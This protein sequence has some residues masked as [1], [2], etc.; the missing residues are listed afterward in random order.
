VAEGTL[1]E[2]KTKLGELGIT[3]RAPL[4][5]KVKKEHWATTLGRH[6]AVNHLSELSD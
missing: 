2:M 1:E 5:E 6:E 3:P 4:G